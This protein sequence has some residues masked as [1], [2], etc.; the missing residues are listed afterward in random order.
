MRLF[1]PNIR[2][3]KAKKDVEGLI[4]ALGHRDEYV[5]ENAVR[6]LGEIGNA[7]AIEGLIKALDDSDWPVREAAAEELGKI[8]DPRAVEHLIKALDD[9]IDV[10]LKAVEALGKIGEPAVEGLIK[11]LDDDI[12]V[13]RE[14]VKA[15]G[16]IGDPRAFDALS[17]LV[18]DDKYV[19][20]FA[21]EALRRIK[22]SDAY[23]PYRIQQAR[24]YEYLHRYEDAAEIYEEFGMLEDARR[25]RELARKPK[26]EI[27][28]DP[29]LLKEKIEE[30]IG[31]EVEIEKLKSDVKILESSKIM[32]EMVEMSYQKT[33]K[34]EYFLDKLK[35]LESY[36]EG[37][38]ERLTNEINIFRRFMKEELFEYVDEKHKV[39]VRRFCK[40]LLDIWITEVLRG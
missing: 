1:K 9:D 35:L 33:I 36:T 19:R 28:I 18:H 31:S 17:E 30:I 29:E 32:V 23:K 7:R 5:R 40:K 24:K 10:R 14:A 2:K 20:E 15:L 6:A 8:G 37:M 4:K 38:S 12:D 39:D 16:E 34:T 25:V 27:T 21:R 22:S 3:L 13:R 26:V 11:A